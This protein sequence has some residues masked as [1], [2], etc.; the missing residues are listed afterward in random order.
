MESNVFTYIIGG[1]AFVIGIIA[2]KL[3]FAKNTKRHIEEAELQANKILSDAKNQAE[4]LKKEKLLEATV[5][6]STETE[7]SAKVKTA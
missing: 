3:I 1:I 7:R 4:T 6:C 2:G 5:K